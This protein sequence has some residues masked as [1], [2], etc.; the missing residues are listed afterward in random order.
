[1]RSFWIKVRI[2]VFGIFLSSCVT[3]TPTPT[4]TQAYKS[5]TPIP[6]PTFAIP[7]IAATETLTPSPVPSATQ[8]PQA[9]LGEV[10]L[11]DDFSENLGWALGDDGTGATSIREGKMIIT[12]HETR[13]FRSALAPV[14]PLVDF[15]LEVEVRP[16]I[17]EPDDEFGF[18]FRVNA[19]FEYYRFALN[20]SGQMKMNRILQNGSRA[21]TPLALAPA[22]IPGPMA[23]NKLAIRTSG[24][25]FR[26]WIND[27]EAFTIRDVSLQSGL[28]G[29]FVRTGRGNQATVSFDNLLLRETLSTQ[30]PTA[31][32][33]TT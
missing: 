29:F 30:P 4:P 7:T 31:T 14:Q 15:Y 9:G 27:I 19:Q 5:P 23:T 1:M 17:C 11:F 2:V 3:S 13:G 24:D 20:C 32:G 33:E 22:V 12:L 8:D 18:M 16:E 25:Q 26:I 10:I 21:L 28:V 6:T